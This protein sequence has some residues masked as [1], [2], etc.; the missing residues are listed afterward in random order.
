MPDRGQRQAPP[1]MISEGATHVVALVAIIIVIV[2]LSFLTVV[3]ARSVPND[4]IDEAV[5]IEAV[6][7]RDDAVDLSSATIA[8]A[9]PPASCFSPS[10]T[11][12]Y[13]HEPEADIPLTAWVVPDDEGG[14]ALDVALAVWRQTDGAMS[15]SACID[16]RGDGAAEQLVMSAAAGGVY[17][18]QVSAQEP[19]QPNAGTVTFLLDEQRPA[20]DLFAF[21]RWVDRTPYRDADVDASGARREP[22]ELRPSCADMEATTWYGISTP[23]DAVLSVS[24]IPSDRPDGTT[25]VALALYSGAAL[26]S[27]VEMA[28]VDSEGA[29][30]AELLELAL[31]GGDVYWLEVGAVL[32]DDA[33]PGVY[34]LEIQGIQTIDLTAIPDTVFGRA[35]LEIAA[36]ASSGLPVSIE[37]EGPCRVRDGSLS[38]LGAGLCTITATQP[39]DA[40]WARA[41]P[42]STTVRIGRGQQSITVEPIPGAVVGEATLIQASADSGL[43]VAFAATGPC[44]IEEGRLVPSGAGTCVLTA[45]QAGDADWA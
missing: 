11:A 10:A 44:A 29:S 36:T 41:L 38:L 18:F 27:L 6:P 45:S 43:P 40:D 16:E 21:A 20:H 28:C 19:L 8:P 14:E 24:V 32:D 17:Y 3:G 26:D 2:A 23:D 33:A 13:V 42:V 30:G 5:A 34:T 22:G 37:A 31:N 7:F 35:P 12:W 15:E 9:E 4:A 25:D 39:G 1:P